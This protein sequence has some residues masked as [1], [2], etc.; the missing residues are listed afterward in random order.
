M[1]LVEQTKTRSGWPICQ[2][3]QALEISSASFYRWRRTLP[4]DRSRMA[5]GSIFQLLNRERQAI[6]DYAL[7]H[8]EVRHRELAWNMVDSG[9]CA[10]SA[11][12]VYRVLREADLVCRWKPKVKT[13]GSGKPNKPTRPDE[14]WQTD[15]RYTKVDARNF[16]LLT[17][18]DVYSR[19]VVY[20]ELLRRMDGLSVSIAAAEALAKLDTD[21]RPIVQSDHGSAFIAG[22]FAGTLSEAKVGH[23]LIRPH[24]PTDNGIIERY[25][26]TVGEQ[27]EQHDL[28]DYT[29]ARQVIAQI[30]DHYNNH[31][32]HS[33][34]SYLRPVDYYRGKP[35]ELLAQRRRKL[36]QARE[37]RKQ[38]NLKLKQRQ[39]PW[40]NTKPS[41]N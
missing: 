40:S 30:V 4:E 35:A 31:R 11:T 14:L 16:Y 17:F 5:Q 15:I 25:H 28:E 6:I 33:A 7:A 41:L 39:L 1:A 32:L 24:T 36:E 29:Q 20:H 9:V 12:T 2:T 3:L 34:L 18:I 37:L 8:P 21:T 26:R 19:Y 13:K 10:V 38:E 27:I 23:T 22:E